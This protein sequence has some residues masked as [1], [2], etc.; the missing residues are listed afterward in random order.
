MSRHHFD[1]V[2]HWRIAAPADRVWAVLTAVQAWPDWWP[3]VLSVQTLR[4]GGARGLGS[5]QR[6]EWATRLPYALVI[7]VEAIESVPPERLRGRSSGHLR[8]EG[9][10]LLSEADHCTDVTYVWRVEL[11]NPWMRC[12]T[13]LLA[14][15]FR[16]NHES[17]MRAGGA[18]LAR[19]LGTAPLASAHSVR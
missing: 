7:E 4:P 9:I 12:L 17:V 18:G 1:L 2:S 10:W 15:L 6:I 19:Y 11:T 13:P 5:V 16:W 8:G 14:P 3:C